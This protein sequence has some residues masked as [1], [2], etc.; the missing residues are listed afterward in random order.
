MN[1]LE[2]K[3]DPAL[4]QRVHRSA[5]IALSAITEAYKEPSGLRIVLTNGIQVKVS[6]SYTEV[7][8][9]YIY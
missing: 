4:F 8:R 7:F 9:N 1:E 3:L 6:R 5:I 2:K